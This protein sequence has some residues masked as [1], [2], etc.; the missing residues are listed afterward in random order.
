MITN[1]NIV[2]QLNFHLKPKT[3]CFPSPPTIFI[4]NLCVYSSNIPLIM[5]VN[6]ICVFMFT[7]NL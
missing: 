3:P 2:R 4:I 1:F 6:L 7:K 5:V